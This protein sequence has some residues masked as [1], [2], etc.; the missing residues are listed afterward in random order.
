[1]PLGCPPV[2]ACT[3]TEP[4]AS[5]VGFGSAKRAVPISKVEPPASRLATVPEIVIPGAAALSVTPLSTTR[6]DCTWTSKPSISTPG[7]TGDVRSGIVLEPITR[8]PDWLRLMMVPSTVAA[9]P[10][11]EIVIPAMEN[12]E[13]FGVNFWPATV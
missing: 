2:K 11:T 7:E 1:M 6:E 5:P 3:L 12:A 13:G 10:P 9:G 4:F 8:V